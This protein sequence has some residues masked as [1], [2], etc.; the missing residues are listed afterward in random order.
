DVQ[1]MFAYSHYYLDHASEVI[2]IYPYQKN[3]FEDEICFKFN[4]QNDQ[5]MLR[6]IPFNL[7]KPYDFIKSIS[8]SNFESE[9]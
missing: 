5:A 7:D 4:V 3:K 9:I 2:L 6:V 8:S 1:Q